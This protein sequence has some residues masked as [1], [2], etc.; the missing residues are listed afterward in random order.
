[1]YTILKSLIFILLLALAPLTL[2][3]PIKIAFINPAPQGNV[4]WDIVVSYMQASANDLKIDLNIYYTLPKQ[5][6]K[7]FNKVKKVLESNDKPDFLIGVFQ[8]Q[9]TLKLLNLSTKHKVGFYSINTQVPDELVES[10]GSPR[11]KFKYWL[12]QSIPN[13]KQAGYLMA[14]SLIDQ[15]KK[16]NSNKQSIQVLAVSGTRDSSASFERNKGLYQALNDH[17]DVLLNQ[18]VFT[19]WSSLSAYK[20][21]KGLLKRYPKTRIIWA[22]SDSIAIGVSKVIADKPILTAGIDWSQPGIE[23]VKQQKITSTYGG[24]FLE[25]GFALVLLYDYSRGRDF[26]QDPGLTNRTPFSKIS[27]SNINEFKGIYSKEFAEKINFRRF[28]KIYNPNVKS[29]NFNWPEIF[30]NLEQ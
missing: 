12:G 15:V 22:A 25:G 6:D 2:S 5:R 28:S 19:D 13:D 8:K 26:K 29:Y 17:P 24:H 23:A 16:S 1:M 20:K 27:L 11:G 4:F 9:T 14:T 10:S 7:N 21:T 3:A 30:R 18:V